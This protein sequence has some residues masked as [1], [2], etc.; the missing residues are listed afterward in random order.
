[1]FFGHRHRTRFR[2][3]FCLASVFEN[4]ILFTYLLTYKSTTPANSRGEYAALSNTS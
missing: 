4:E 2:D 3:S 1:M